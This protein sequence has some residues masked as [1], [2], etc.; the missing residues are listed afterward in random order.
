M[1]ER[2][3]A[4]RS[5]AHL[6]H[7]YTLSPEHGAGHALKPSGRLVLF[8]LDEEVARRFSAECTEHRVQW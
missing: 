8:R 1:D 6:G 5:D 2:G 3:C 7:A 4:R